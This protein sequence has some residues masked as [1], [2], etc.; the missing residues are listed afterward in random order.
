LSPKVGIVVPTLGTRPEYLKQCLESIRAAGDAYVLLVA[1]KGFD[2]LKL[3]ADGLIDGVEE[4]PRTGVSDAINFGMNSLPPEVEI[5]NWLGDDDVLTKNSLASALEV[6]T[7]D[8]QTVMVFGSCN[9]IDARGEIIWTNH[10]GQWAVPLL[11]F[12]PDLIPQPGALFR[13][14][15]FE[16]IGGL[17]SDFDWA[18][19]FDLFIRLSKLGKLKH[20]KQTLASFRWHPESLS[21]EHRRKSVAEA[22]AVR[23]RHLPRLLR[24]ISIVWE[25]PVKQ[26]TLWAGKRVSRRAR[27]KMQSK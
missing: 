2:W 1:P 9:Y 26:A 25:F 23:H 6:F 24:P 18:F 14:S 3:K 22:S 13:R 19:D 16:R 11:R 20:I 21:V 5:V 8:N 12:G 4:D 15:A 27:K 7:S 17:S 10:S